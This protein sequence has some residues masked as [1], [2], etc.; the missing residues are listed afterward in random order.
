MNVCTYYFCVFFE[1]MQGKGLF[2]IC[3]FLSYIAGYAQVPG[4]AQKDFDRA[5]EYKAKKQQANANEYMRYAIKEYPAYIDAYSTLG[6]WYYDAHQ[7]K[8]AAELFTSASRNCKD[9]YKAFAKPLVKSLLN[10]YNPEGA[11]LILAGYTPAKDNGEWKKLREQA[12]FMQQALRNPN[13]D[14][15]I[16]LSA[17]V[18]SKDPE[19]YPYI[20]SDTQTLYFTR[21][22][23]GIDE[24]LYRSKA[25]TCGG[26]LYARNLG[27]PPNTSALEA[28]QMISADNH[29]LFFTR[30][31]NKSENGWDQGGCDL[32]MAYTGDSIWSIPQ[33]F[34]ATINTPDYQGMPCLS[35]DNRE[36]FFVSDKPGGQGGFDIWVSRF[37]DGLWQDPKNLGPN[38][39]T[40]GD[41]TA[42]F[43]H[44]DNNTLY[45]ASN[46]H[47]GM[48]GSDI[49]MCKRINDSTWSKPIN[50]GYPINS[51]AD[52]ISA[53]ITIDG[54]RI[55]FASDRDSVSG[56]FDIY[57]AK[58]PTALQPQPVVIL[59]GYT[60]DSLTKEKLNYGSVYINDDKGNQLFHFV[61]NRGDGSYMIT[62]P[63][64]KKFVYNA[65]RMG[66]MDITDT[67][68]FTK[69][70]AFQ[71]IKY[72]I[73]LLPQGYEKPINDSLL[74]TIHFARNMATLSDS[75]KANLVH[76]LDPWLLQKDFV[77]LVNGYTD[78]SGTPIINEQLSFMRAG[79]VTQAIT[80]LGV[81]PTAIQSKGWGEANPVAPNDNEENMTLNRRV[82]I[83]I[84]R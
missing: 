18:N 8:E 52:E 22:V 45:F 74:L 84:R 44:I 79:L 29:Y 23:N 41:E 31:D 64:G 65:G 76:V 68:Y 47:T 62:L 16:H 2:F 15:P 50:L 53:S 33:S 56:N 49:Y 37:E 11:L 67:M 70:Q 9:G 80:D 73:P 30:C 77:L 59:K 51:M 58:T 12:L 5:M 81:D 78:V 36:L 10:C 57:E 13:T 39:N 4:R 72:N 20:S 24:D 63:V 69:E 48:G 42:P 28:A 55:F 3:F 75:D 6:Q 1:S 19:M 83:I 26:W 61:S 17:R 27:S 25:D 14:S 43:L 21:R 46:G 54:K 34:G 35:A 32:Y 38:V 82:E 60:Y 7:Y 40:P 66:Y 71:T